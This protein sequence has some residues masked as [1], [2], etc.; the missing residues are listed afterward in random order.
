MDHAGSFRPMFEP[1]Q[2]S[3]F[4]AFSYNIYLLRPKFVLVLIASFYI[5]LHRNTS[6]CILPSSYRIAV[7]RVNSCQFLLVC[8]SSLCIPI[9]SLWFALVRI[10]SVH[11]FL[12]HRC[13]SCLHRVNSYWFLLVCMSSLRILLHRIESCQASNTDQCESARNW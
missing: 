4:W 13:T 12:L 7:L 2:F 6:F 3:T 5:V 1:G 11:T 9:S 10:S 8:I